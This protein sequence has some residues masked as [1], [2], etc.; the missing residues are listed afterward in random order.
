MGLLSLEI[1]CRAPN[2]GDALSRLV[3]QERFE[4]VG[5][6]GIRSVI[7]TR[8]TC[9]MPTRGMQKDLLPPFLDVDDRGSRERGLLGER[10]LSDGPRARF[11]NRAFLRGSPAT[12]FSDFG[13]C[14][15]SPALAAVFGTLSP[16][17][18]I[19][20]PAAGFGTKSDRT[21]S[22]NSAFCAAVIQGSLV[23]QLFRIEVRAPQTVG[24]I[25]SADRGAARCDAA[26]KA[27]FYCCF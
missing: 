5:G 7:G 20:F 17:P 6:R 3:A 12:Y 25:R 10:F 27:T 22:R 21:C 8:S 26:G 16:H 23:G 4:T 2:P 19:P 13:L 15:R 1:A 9:A 14:G 11:R 24:S 18:K